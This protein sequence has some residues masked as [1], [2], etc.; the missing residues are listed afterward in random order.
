MAASFQITHYRFAWASEPANAI[1]NWLADE[2]TSPDEWPF[3]IPLYFVFQLKNT[4][5][6]AGYPHWKLHYKL[7]GTLVPVTVRD[8]GPPDTDIEPFRTGWLKDDTDI[9]AAGHQ[10]SDEGTLAGAIYM[11]AG[12]IAQPTTDEPVA[13]GETYEV[14]LA[15]SLNEDKLA[16][17]DV[18]E[19]LLVHYTTAAVIPAAYAAAPEVTV[20]SWYTLTVPLAAKA[21]DAGDVNTIW[22]DSWPYVQYE[23]A[24]R[25]QLPTL[26]RNAT[27]KAATVHQHSYTSSIAGAFPW[28]VGLIDAK[29][30]PDL[31]SRHTAAPYATVPW[32]FDA[33]GADLDSG[34]LI[35]SPDIASL[36]QSWL[37]GRGEGETPATSDYLGLHFKLD[38][39]RTG[40]FT[41]KTADYI[42]GMAD[43]PAL[44]VAYTLPQLTVRERRQLKPP[45]GWV[46][47]NDG[48]PID[49]IY[50]GLEGL[51]IF[52]EGT[53]DLV[54][55][56][57]GHGR[58]GTVVG[59]TWVAGPSGWL[60]SFDGRNDYVSCPCPIATWSADYSVLIRY[61]Q[62]SQDGYD[63][64]FGVINSAGNAPCIRSLSGIAA[65]PA[66]VSWAHYDT[67]T[68]QST[69]SVIINDSW[70][71]VVGGVAGN[72]PHIYV[73]K[74]GTAF[75]SI[76]A[77]ALLDR[78]APHAVC[79]FGCG[80][81]STGTKLCAHCEIDYAAIWSRVLSAAEVKRLHENPPWLLH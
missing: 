64:V 63:G 14:V 46:L 28:S 47:G 65:K 76:R 54:A 73:W 58:H 31:S 81:S 22:Q 8:S 33:P 37:R 5:D 77:E 80:V 55:D 42:T 11:D 75:H 29:S 56:C 19:P 23:G 62:W 26:P 3:G 79:W 52:N 38:G 50:R 51:W 18:V 25:W 61:R 15:L 20:A 40:H 60:G 35:P 69:S 4:G 71:S 1:T 74:S 7:N 16:W 57:S 68:I 10:L 30:C 12:I 53:G 49:P 67:T 43:A 9:T 21:D 2:D 13:A 6:A 72:Q 48:R 41:T 78:A 70:V 59:A 17:A 32:Y 45:R 27:I 36:V 66:T 34:H 24:M 39:S 44:Y